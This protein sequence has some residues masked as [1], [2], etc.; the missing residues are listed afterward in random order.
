MTV[1]K[2]EMEVEKKERK[3]WRSVHMQERGYKERESNLHQFFLLIEPL[4]E[5]LL[6]IRERER[7]ICIKKK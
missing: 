1:K 4:I 3:R 2:E 6:K 7:A 5:I